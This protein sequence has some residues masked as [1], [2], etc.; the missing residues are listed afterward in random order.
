[1]IVNFTRYPNKSIKLHA[2]E[3]AIK[4]KS[5]SKLEQIHLIQALALCDLTDLTTLKVIVEL[6]W[7]NSEN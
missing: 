2:V 5:L 4:Q 7:T 3:I 6:C 1:M